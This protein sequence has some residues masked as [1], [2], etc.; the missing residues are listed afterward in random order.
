MYSIIIILKEVF[1]RQPD[2]HQE[3][4]FTIHNIVQFQLIM[5]VNE[6]NILRIGDV[7]TLF[8]GTNTVNDEGDSLEALTGGWLC[9]E[10]Q[11]GVDC[12]LTNNQEHIQ[13]SLDFVASLSGK[14]FN[15]TD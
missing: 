10:G 9:A 6:K 12:M 1:S 7:V 4:R 3:N 11:L 15:T 5:A 2:L 14:I 8:H 13:V